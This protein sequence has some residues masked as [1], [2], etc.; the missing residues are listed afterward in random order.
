MKDK[1]DHESVF[2]P[3]KLQRLFIE[4]NGPGDRMVRW[5]VQLDE[6]ML[7]LPNRETGKPYEFQLHGHI[8]T[9]QF[10]SS[11]EDRLRNQREAIDRLTRH[12]KED[13]PQ[14]RGTGTCPHLP[15]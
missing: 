1:V 10:F 3:L 2:T 14:L 12:L 4:G 6:N 5:S 8:V 7:W 9:A 11:V 15:G 13:C